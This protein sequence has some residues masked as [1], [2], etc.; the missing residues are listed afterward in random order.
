M[1]YEV[2]IKYVKKIILTC[3][4]HKKEGNVQT[5]PFQNFEKELMTKLW[6]GGKKK[7]R[8][9]EEKGS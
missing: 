7:K 6:G 3:S 8:R 5:L 1:L 4:S 9:K 2:I